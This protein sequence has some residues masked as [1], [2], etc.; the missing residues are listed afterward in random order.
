MS[1]VFD[2]APYVASHQR[3]PRGRGSWAFQPR[4]A[5]QPDGQP[6]DERTI[7]SPSLTL[8]EARRWLRR[9]QPAGTYDLLP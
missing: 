8:T 6:I 3:Q 1:H 7:W 9:T 5:Y 2:D 4:D